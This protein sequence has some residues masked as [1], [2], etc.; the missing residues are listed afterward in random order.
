MWEVGALDGHLPIPHAS[1]LEQVPPWDDEE[2]VVPSGMGGCGA[3]VAQWV[4]NGVGQCCGWEH[5]PK[6]MRGPGAR[7]DRRFGRRILDTH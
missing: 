7:G 2:A 4:A 3:K 1:L 5:E 6:R